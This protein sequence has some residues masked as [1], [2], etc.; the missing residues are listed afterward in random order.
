[1]HCWRRVAFS[2]QRLSR[3]LRIKTIAKLLRRQSSGKLGTPTSRLANS[4]S[5]ASRASTTSRLHGGGRY[6][7]RC[8]QDH[9]AFCSGGCRGTDNGELVSRSGVPFAAN[10]GGFSQA[11]RTRTRSSLIGMKGDAAVRLS[12]YFDLVTAI[13]QLPLCNYA[14]VSEKGHGLG[15]TGLPPIL[16]V[17]DGLVGWS[18]WR[19]VDRT[20]WIAGITN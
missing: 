8:D 16:P 13:D 1:M 6:G 2:H 12:R 5:K 11:Q 4:A 9:V 3:P 19:H 17:F 7:T 14:R 15:L 18:F 20:E 10:A